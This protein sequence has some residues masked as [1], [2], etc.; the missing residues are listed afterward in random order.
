MD[1]LHDQRLALSQCKSDVM[2]ARRPNND[3]FVILKL[4]LVC[5][6][7]GVYKTIKQK[8]NIT[9]TQ[10]HG[11]LLTRIIRLVIVGF[12][13]FRVGEQAA[14]EEMLNNGE[15]LQHLENNAKTITH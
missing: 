5:F 14:K 11:T 2:R 9:D 15:F 13:P 6:V 8:L 10:R 7:K 4:M 12:L 3:S 1:S